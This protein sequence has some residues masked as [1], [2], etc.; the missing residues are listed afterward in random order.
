[1]SSMEIEQYRTY[2]ARVKLRKDDFKYKD[3]VL[4]LDGR[5]FEFVALWPIENGDSTPFPAGEF[6][7]QCVGR[8]LYWI[9]SGDLE[10]LKVERDD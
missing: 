9:A 5:V 1:M 2:R 6:A 8:E 7:M 3:D 10:I 4:C